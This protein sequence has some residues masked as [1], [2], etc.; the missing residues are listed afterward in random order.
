MGPA[1]RRDDDHAEGEPEPEPEPGSESGVCEMEPADGRL[2]FRTTEHY[3]D[4]VWSYH[5]HDPDDSRWTLESYTRLADVSSV[6]GF[7]P[8]HAATLPYLARGIFFVMREHVFPCWDDPHNIDGGCLS[9]KVL[10]DDVPAF[11]EHLLLHALC[12]TLV[13][14]PDAASDRPSVNGLSASP[15]RFFCI[16]KVWLADC[17]RT[18][19]EDFRLPPGYS[20]EVLF[21]L[22]RDNMR[23][24]MARQHSHAP[25][26]PD[27]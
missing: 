13:A 16:I 6:E 24:N 14:A 20:G 10:K 4:D 25:A 23:D 5:F 3:L 27:P 26:A 19:R 7:W 12:D 11:W 1:D 22:N 15:K 2:T 21:K 18:C 8:V 9:M 17:R